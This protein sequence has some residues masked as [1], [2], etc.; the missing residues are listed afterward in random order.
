[1]T[2]GAAAFRALVAEVV[3]PAMLW[4]VGVAGRNDRPPWRRLWVTYPPLSCSSIGPL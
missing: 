3:E 1:V 4:P 2:S